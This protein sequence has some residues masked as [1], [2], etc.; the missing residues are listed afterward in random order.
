MS[1]RLRRATHGLLTRAHAPYQTTVLPGT[2]AHR[3]GVAPPVMH[4]LRSSGPE[5]EGGRIPLAPTG[6]KR[7]PHRMGVSYV[8]PVP[9]RHLLVSMVARARELSRWFV[10]WG[11]P[12]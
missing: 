2:D 8:K 5:P 1:N 11:A 10:Q 7:V 12:R 9:S 3:E 4:L 6:R